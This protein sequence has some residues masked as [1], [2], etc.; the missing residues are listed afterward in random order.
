MPG[1]Q[2]KPSL[3]G[4]AMPD[5]SVSREV[6]RVFHQ[7]VP[8]Y[9]ETGTSITFH[10]NREED[11]PLEKVTAIQAPF[12]HKDSVIGT[13][14]S[15]YDAAGEVVRT[16]ITNPE[17][18]IPKAKED[19]YDKELQKAMAM[20]I[21]IAQ[22]VSNDELFNGLPKSRK[23]RLPEDVRYISLKRITNYILNMKELEA[24]KASSGE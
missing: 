10:P 12:P 2:G 7:G 4:A 20:L 17:I 23:D 16:L 22:V 8:A 9:N 18:K 13:V 6:T 5:I 24:A 14:W 19:P 15:F 11:A 1:Q 21:A 3:F